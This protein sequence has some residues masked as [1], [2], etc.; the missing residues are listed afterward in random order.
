[1]NRFAAALSCH[2]VS[3]LAAGE[4]AGAVLEQLGGDAPDLVVAF[5]SP[6]F[7]GAVEDMADALVELLEP[8]ALVGAVMAAVI[9]G[10]REVEDGPA[11][12]LWAATLPDSEVRPLELRVEEVSSGAA[13]VGWPADRPAPDGGTATLLLLADPFTFPI[14][15]VLASLD[16][17]APDVQVVGGLASAARGPG[18]NR[19]LLGR[20]ALTQGAVGVL[21]SGGPPVGTLVSQG[22]RPFGRPFTVTAADGHHLVELGGRPALERLQALAAE[23]PEEDRELL[24]GA[25]Q[26][27]FVL[28]E[29]RDEFGRGDFLVRSVVGAREAAGAFAVGAAVEIGQTVQFHLRDPVA[30]DEDL[31]A[32]LAGRDAAAA[33]L[34]TCT[35]RGRALFGTEDHDAA[36]VGDA[37]G[38]VPVTGAFCA[39]ELGPVGGRSHVHTFSASLALFA[40]QR[41]A[42][43]PAI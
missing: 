37:F 25:L 28:D 41:E 9:G 31:R 40:G 3:A 32:L 22:C 27:G 19:L 14:E 36:L 6:H 17:T 34:F 42:G 38:A 1:V 35:G 23:L 5:C 18:G 13:L 7:A 12:A 20:G 8:T 16:A 21:L 2:P 26:V 10:A 4:V 33:L 39:G 24:S 29:H 11:L 30:A 43:T 15:G